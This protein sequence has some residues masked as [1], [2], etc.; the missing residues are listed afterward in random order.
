[1]MN[2]MMLEPAD[3]LCAQASIATFFHNFSASLHH[4]EYDEYG[5]EYGDEYDDA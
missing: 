3:L 1:M 2:T 4:C 5:V